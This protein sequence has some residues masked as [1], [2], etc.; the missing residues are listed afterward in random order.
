MLLE[1]LQKTNG[2][3]QLACTAR[4]HLIIIQPSRMLLEVPYIFNGP[5][6]HERSVIYDLC[7]NTMTAVNGIGSCA[8][9]P[10]PYIIPQL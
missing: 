10:H 4:L 9:D 7:E 5:S 3:P 8:S 6:Q 1:L 2:K